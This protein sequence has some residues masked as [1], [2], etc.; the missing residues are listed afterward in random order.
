MHPREKE[1]REFAGTAAAQQY[2]SPPPKGILF[3]DGTAGLPQC[4]SIKWC[5]KK[6]PKHYK[7]KLHSDISF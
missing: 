6:H 4:L 3:F 7:K 1:E 2:A 5:N